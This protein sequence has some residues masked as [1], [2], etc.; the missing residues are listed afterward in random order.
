MGRAR[1]RK[2]QGRGVALV[3]GRGKRAAA[4]ETS[5][6][7][8]GR[9]NAVLQSLSSDGFWIRGCGTSLQGNMAC[10]GMRKVC[11]EKKKGNA[12]S[13]FESAI[14]MDGGYSDYPRG[15]GNGPE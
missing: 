7:R 14:K 13:R 3:G 5:K 12:T 1:A 4:L 11:R 8:G 2:K 10:G 9:V 15:R 6:G